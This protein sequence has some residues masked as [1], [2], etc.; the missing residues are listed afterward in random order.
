MLHGETYVGQLFPW[1]SAGSF[2]TAVTVQVD[3]LSAV[4]LLVVTGVGFLIHVYSAGYMHGDDSFARFFDI[5]LITVEPAQAGVGIGN[6]GRDRLIHFVREG[7]SQLSHRGHPAH[8]CQI[9]LCLTQSHFGA[10]AGLLNTPFHLHQ[11]SND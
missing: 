4:M 11:S 10:I 8:P 5:G 3:Q 1:I 9:R 6:G 2:T 7:S